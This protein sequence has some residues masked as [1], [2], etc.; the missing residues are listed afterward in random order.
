MAR[1]GLITQVRTGSS[2][3]PA[4]VFKKILNRPTLDFFIER[5]R[6][7]PKLD[8]VI[9][10]TT[11]LPEDDQVVDFCVEK[12]IPYFRGS[13]EDVLDR[14]YQTAKKFNLQHIVRITSDCPLLDPQVSLEVINFYLTEKKWDYVSN[15][16]KSI[17]PHGLDTEI[18]SIEALKKAAQNARLKEEREHVTP[19]MRK[20]E[21]KLRFTQALTNLTENYSHHR[22][23]LD[24]P[25]D[26]EFIRRVLEELYPK[27]PNFSWR[28]IIQFLELKPEISHINKAR[29]AQ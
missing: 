19:Y 2:R 6:K 14:Y 18:F 12:K 21:N 24:Y 23:T 5:A 1:L 4:K 22:W 7:I 26:F 10:A 11:N 27:N 15:N 8:E 20:P 3:L 25:E 9:I 29:R 28:D 16:L 17:Y 13:A